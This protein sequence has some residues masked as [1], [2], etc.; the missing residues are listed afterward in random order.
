MMGQFDMSSDD[1]DLKTMINGRSGDHGSFIM[2]ILD[3]VVE[4]SCFSSLGIEDYNPTSYLD[5]LEQ[6]LVAPPYW[7]DHDNH[8]SMMCS[9][10]EVNKAP[11]EEESEPQAKKR[12]LS[13]DDRDDAIA[14]ASAQKRRLPRKRKSKITVVHQAS[15]EPSVP[16]KWNWRKY[17]QKPIK[18]SPYPRSYYKCS[19]SIGCQAKKQ[20]EQSNTNPRTYI[21]TYISEHSHPLPTRRPSNQPASKTRKHSP[22][23]TDKIS[24]DVSSGPVK[25]EHISEVK[26]GQDYGINEMKREEDDEVLSADMI[27]QDFS[28]SA[29]IL[30]SMYNQDVAS[31]DHFPLIFT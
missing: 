20:V 10:V 2:S 8:A 21:I 19:G 23:S 27:W 16:D 25:D 6:L 1:W 24:S 26:Q 28:G 7:D 11:A 31:F 14:P 30:D 13:S 22:F 4:P 12:R 17:G 18:G 5:E 29:S 15:E 9:G 3:D